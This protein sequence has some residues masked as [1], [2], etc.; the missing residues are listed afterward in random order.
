MIN[1]WLLLKFCSPPL[2]RL[3]WAGYGPGLVI[4]KCEF[5]SFRK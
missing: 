3:C 1:I 5:F 2:P 4:R